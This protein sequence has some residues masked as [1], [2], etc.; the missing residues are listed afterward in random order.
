MH[1]LRTYISHK[2]LW[3]EELHFCFHLNHL[4]WSSHDEVILLQSVLKDVNLVCTE[5]FFFR[6]RDIRFNVSTSDHFT[7]SCKF[8]IDNLYARSMIINR[9]ASHNYARLSSTPAFC[10]PVQSSS[11]KARSV[12]MESV[13][14][15]KKA[16]CVRQENACLTMQDEQLISD[17]DA[18]QYELASFKSQ[19]WQSSLDR[20]FGWINML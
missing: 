2:Y 20:W 12:E 9:A 16:G 3:I 14:S 8:N 18:M 1:V 19:V 6:E 17:L 13:S 15:R 10:L 7:I 11:V 4:R 5:I